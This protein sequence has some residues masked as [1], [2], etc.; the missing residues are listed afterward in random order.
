MRGIATPE[1]GR[2]SRLVKEAGVAGIARR[3]AGRVRSFVYLDE[4]HIWYTLNLDGVEQRP[5]AEGY[6]LRLGTDADMERITGLGG[7]SL[8]DADENRAR[9][10]EA[11]LVEQGEETAFVCWIFPES[12]PVRAAADRWLA[13]PPGVACLED[14]FTDASH[15]G[16]G[17]AGAAWTKI[18]QGLKKRDFGV[19]IT[20]VDVDNA[21]S[22][23]AVQKAGFR[24]ACLMRLR[25][26]GPREAVT[27]ETLPTELT[28]AEQTAAG[29]IK[30]RLERH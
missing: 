25:R 2:L 13:L 14:S 5:L 4:Q 7:T 6:E 22:R 17:I 12:T 3:I 15:R 23:K 9:G 16:R 26:R 18:A 11:W 27:V 21:P 24:E 10:A 29:E 1:R 28:P 20:K 19:L 8:E 30:Q